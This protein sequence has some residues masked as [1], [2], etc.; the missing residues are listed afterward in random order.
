MALTN[1]QRQKAYR[2]RRRQV[3]AIR[4]TYG[5]PPATSATIRPA[6]KRWI[7]LTETTRTAATTIADELETFI[8]NR[9][10]AWK[11]GPRGEHLAEQLEQLQTIIEQVDELVWDYPE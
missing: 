6:F 4:A 2:D 1:A 10:D 9:S 3:N 11:D 5:F 7:Q 8:N